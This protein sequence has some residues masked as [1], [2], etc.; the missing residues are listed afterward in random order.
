M[1]KTFIQTAH[2]CDIGRETTDSVF[3]IGLALHKQQSVWL[4]MEIKE[5]LKKKD[6]KWTQSCKKNKNNTA[7][8]NNCI[9]KKK[10]KCHIKSRLK[11]KNVLVKLPCSFQELWNVIVRL[12]SSNIGQFNALTNR[13]CFHQNLCCAKQ[14]P[15]KTKKGNVL[16]KN[17]SVKNKHEN[18]KS[19]SHT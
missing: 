11:K 3:C 2:F 4:N 14:K 16:L 1:F 19:Q 7:I 10:H 13:S 18:H 17:M 5:S 9:K 6:I 15:Q 12:L 8:C